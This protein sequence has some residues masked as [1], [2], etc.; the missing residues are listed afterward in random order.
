[1]ITL[2][3]MI[4]KIK[5]L[6]GDCAALDSSYGNLCQGFGENEGFLLSSF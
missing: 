4:M 2:Q 3:V 5:V 6:G 1:M